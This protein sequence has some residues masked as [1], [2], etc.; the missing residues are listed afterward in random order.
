MKTLLAAINAQ[1]IHTNLAVRYL[2]RFRN[3]Y[4]RQAIS[5]VEFT[6]NQLPEHI[7]SQI[8]ELEPDLLCFSCYLWNIQT[9]LQLAEDYKQLR[10]NTKI[11]L[12][13]P[14]VSYDGEALL[15]SSPSVDYIIAGEGE[16]V[17]EPL[18]DCL[19]GEGN[20][21]EN[22][23]AVPGLVYRREDGQICA[24]PRPP[25]LE[26]ALLPFPYEGELESLDNRL[27]YYETSRGCPFNCRYCLSSAEQGVRFQPL[28]KVFRELQY[29]LDA[30]V[31]QVK[32]VDRT[33]NC[34]RPHYRPI[35]EY[36]IAHDNG[37]T[38]FHLEISADLLEEEDMTIFSQARPGLFQLEIGVQSTHPQ[39]AAAIDRHAP[40]AK[41]A[42]AV[43]QIHS[44]GNIHCHLD[45]IA[46]LPQENYGSFAK[47]FDDVFSL[48]PEQFQLGFLKLLKGS[49]L[50]EHADGLGLRFRS[51]P[52]YEVLSSDR[53]SFGELLR[54]KGV[55]EMVDI[56]YNSGRFQQTLEYLLGR[57]MLYPAGKSSSFYFF[58]ALADFWKKSG[59]QNAAQGQKQLYTLLWNFYRESEGFR[60]SRRDLSSADPGT[61]PFQSAILFDLCRHKKPYDIPS[62][63][64]ERPSVAHREEILRFYRNPDNIH[65]YLPQY[66]GLDPRQIAKLAHIEL[67]W[68][69]EERSWLPVLFD[70]DHRDLLGNA[71]ATKLYLELQ[72]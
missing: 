15:R 56:Y 6:V 57:W 26:L 53:L 60:S 34:K 59:C 29:F 72:I 17:L 55:E 58:E 70:Y 43:K 63:L 31:R 39:T 11:L 14:E 65:R 49:Y 41:I 54:L 52:P 9:V 25:A 10:P 38:N 3:L 21:E 46:G 12:G 27:L 5:F 2:Y 4:K 24:N 37:V 69:P 44:L 7:F 19:S 16:L 18:L 36:L 51:S 28:D 48:R 23:S 71:R 64:G 35:L 42:N 45:L 47:S 67:F 68:L 61:G 8:Y 32:L 40:F 1:Y 13:G 62:W 50:R 33:F 22:L 20:A 66:V 30:R